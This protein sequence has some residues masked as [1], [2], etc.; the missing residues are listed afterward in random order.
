MT[1]SCLLRLATRSTSHAAGL[2]R[3]VSA[4]SVSGSAINDG[5]IS[6]Y[7]EFF[8]M[9]DRNETSFNATAIEAARR[10][11]PVMKCGV[12]E[13]NL[14]FS[15]ICYGRLQLAPHVMP[16]EHRVVMKVHLADLPISTQL[17]KVILREIVGKRLSDEKN[18]LQIQSNIFGSR[19]ENKR[20]LVSMLDRIIIGTKSL[21]KE[22][23][24]QEEEMEK[25]A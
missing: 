24:K 2:G 14:E 22:M 13:D 9:I 7:Q 12:L 17:E 4:L 25:E 19:I 6:P 8:D 20:H 16:L 10:P 18:I 1:R 3:N 21:A 15:T 5:Y 11:S 23:E